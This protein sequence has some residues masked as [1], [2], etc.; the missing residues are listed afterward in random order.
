MAD[1]ESTPPESTPPGPDPADPAEPAPVEPAPVETAPV[2][3][4][5]RL[6][7]TVWNFRSMV[8]V[9]VASLLIGGAA[10]AAITALADDDHAA[11]R[12][13]AAFGERGEGFGRGP[14][15][16]DGRPGQPLPPRPGLRQRDW[17]GRQ[18]SPDADETAPANP[19]SPE[20]G[21]SA[22]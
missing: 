14:G 12:R 18:P 22:G 9:A 20:E 4:G 7:D 3:T 6:R 8:V 10:G 11:P 15:G 17:Q 5:P 2:E 1:Q 16:F 19:A 21:S 13:P